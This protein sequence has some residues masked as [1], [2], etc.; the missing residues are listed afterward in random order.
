MNELVGSRSKNFSAWNINVNHGQWLYPDPDSH[1]PD[2]WSNCG[3]GKKWYGW[4][5]SPGNE[6]EK[7]GS[8]S[9]IL[10]VSGKVRLSFGNCWNSGDVSV[11]LNGVLKSSAIP[12]SHHKST[13]WFEAG[14]ELK[15]CDEGH[16]SIIQFD[17][18]ELSNC[19]LT[20]TTTTTTTTTITPKTTTTTTN[21][22]KTTTT[23]TILTATTSTTST[24]STMI[25]TI[26]KE[27]GECA[28]SIFLGSVPANYSVNCM[29]K[30]WSHNSCNFGSFSPYQHDCLLFETCTRLETDL[31]PNC[32]TSATE[33]SHCEFPGLCLVSISNL[34]LVPIRFYVK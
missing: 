18:I 20:T 4:N 32:V 25:P 6:I 19:F 9:T 12:N 1:V 16:N 8:I 34:I 33:C 31:C 2:V 24:T 10:P 30:C 11:Y 17:F 27:P 5:G 3:E 21:P 14:D 29:N 22:P 13:F 28:N 15:I 7:T 26:C 23:I